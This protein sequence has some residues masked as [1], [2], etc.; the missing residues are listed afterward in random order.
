MKILHHRLIRCTAYLWAGLTGLLL[1]GCDSAPSPP[2]PEANQMVYFDRGTKRAVVYNI[3][4]E[5][6]EIHPQTGK[7]TLVPASYCPPVSYTHL[8]LPT[9]YSV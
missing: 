9:I 7:P 1:A 3:A 2:K 6:P 5:F 4:S 8:T